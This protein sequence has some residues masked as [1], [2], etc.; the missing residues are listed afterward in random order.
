VAGLFVLAWTLVP[1]QSVQ[2][3]GQ[4]DP[5]QQLAFQATAPV[6]Q[7]ANRFNPGGVFPVGYA[8]LGQPFAT[9]PYEGALYGY[10]SPSYYAG[11]TA[12][13]LAPGAPTD[14][15]FSARAIFSQMLQDG[16]WDQLGASDRATL[17]VQLA[18]LDVSQAT[19][20]REAQ[21]A[22]L[23][24]RRAP[25]ELAALYQSIARDWRDSYT[26]Y[27][28]A[29]QSLAQST[30]TPPNGQTVVSPPNTLFQQCS[31][32]LVRLPICAGFR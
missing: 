3:Q 12:P 20:R 24:Q 11:S 8:P 30:C 5:C 26:F 18:N 17:V 14:P 2:A 15:Q 13:A 22:V 31:T 16:T 29:V 27:G 1:L 28:Q 7:A 25:F 23:A 10:P 4:A 6:L 19:E 9:N 21:A 32:A